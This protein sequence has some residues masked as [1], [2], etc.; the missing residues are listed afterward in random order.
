MICLVL[1]FS[2]GG[3]VSAIKANSDF[4]ILPDAELA[5]VIRDGNDLAFEQMVQRYIRLIC[6][7]AHDFDVDGFEQDDLVQEGLMTL[8]AACQ[9]YNKNVGMSFKNYLALCVKRRYISIV[10]KSKTQSNITLSDTVD[11]EELTDLATHSLNP[12]EILLKK[13]DCGNILS[14]IKH[15]LS[16]LEQNVLYYYLAG[17]K[18]ADI[19]DK[20]GF[21]V[22]SVDNAIQRIHKKL[23]KHFKLQ[24]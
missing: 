15:N 19:S 10:R 20:L 18:Y 21:S 12:E 16:K 2:R 8:F 24:D 13:E 23:D 14:S 11:I 9:T 1:D 17:F 5:L 7:I 6:S 3:L 4:S 22:K